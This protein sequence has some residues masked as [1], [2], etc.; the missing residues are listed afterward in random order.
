MLDQLPT[1]EEQRSAAF[2]SNGASRFATMQTSEAKR[3]QR[4]L[5]VLDGVLVHDLDQELL[6]QIS[7]KFKKIDCVPA[8]YF[9]PELYAA[10]PKQL[11]H[12]SAGTAINPINHR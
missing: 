3:L 11:I 12:R 7:E 4:E 10:S 2:F 5:W 8:G 6:E 1:Q 9:Y